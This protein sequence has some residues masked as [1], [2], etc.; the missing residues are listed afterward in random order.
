MIQNLRL[1]LYII[2]LLLCCLTS[3][4]IASNN[5]SALRRRHI[6][7]K[8]STPKKVAVKKADAEAGLQQNIPW[9]VLTN[10][11]Y[12]W[13]HP[14]GKDWDGYLENS[15]IVVFENTTTRENV[16]AH[17][18]WITDKMKKANNLAARHENGKDSIIQIHCVYEFGYA[19]KFDW[20]MK[21]K[22][23]ARPEVA[24]VEPDPMIS[25]SGYSTTAAAWG[26]DRADQRDLPLDGQITLDGNAGDGVDIYIIDSGINTEH[27]QFGGRA[28]FGAS[29]SSSGTTDGA[30][31][32]THVAGTAGGKTFGVARNSILI[33]VKVIDDDGSGSGSNVIMGLQWVLQAVKFR[34]RPAVVNMS[35]GGPK[36]NALDRA[37]NAAIDAGIVV[38][39]AAGND[40]QDACLESPANLPRVITV[41]ASTE[42]DAK[43]KFSNYGPCVKI[44]A[45]GTKI[46]SSWIGSNIATNTLD[47]TSMSSPLVAGA[48]AA[49]LSD[50]PSLQPQGVLR[51]IQAASTVNRITGLAN[52]PGTP[53]NL[54]FL[55]KASVSQNS[56]VNS[57]PGSA[58]G[59]QKEKVGSGLRSSSKKSQSDIS[60]ISLIVFNCIIVISVF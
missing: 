31:H 59:N 20:E 39:T 55:G 5:D 19:G 41:A 57:I 27:T 49:I 54:L 53:N 36:S 22:I 2:F 50:N 6:P 17:S 38:V 52:F 7:S 24:Y 9:D 48:A 26:I 46:L 42:T 45:A 30:G 33:A 13:S 29:F 15:Y 3:L 1:S 32:G 23:E 28:I 8:K 16:T 35:I 14:R 18:K 56:G 40:N 51:A 43:A 21:K 58:D 10:T 60:F 34:K 37:V 25:I 44:F 4:V 47:G 11:S 12:H